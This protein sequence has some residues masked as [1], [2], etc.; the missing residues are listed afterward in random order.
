MDRVHIGVFFKLTAYFIPFVKTHIIPLDG[1]KRVTVTVRYSA[2][3]DVSE[4]AILNKAAR[5][6]LSGLVERGH[7]ALPSLFLQLE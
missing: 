1:V 3:E 5:M 6:V 7:S 2:A 4:E